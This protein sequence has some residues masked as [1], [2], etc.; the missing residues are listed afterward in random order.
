MTTTVWAVSLVAGE[1]V[2]FRQSA[3]IVFMSG[4]IVVLKRLFAA[5]VLYARL[6]FRPSTLNSEITTG[7]DGFINPDI[8]NSFPVSI[9]KE[10]GLFEIW[11]LIL[12]AIG[13]EH[14]ARITRRSAATVTALTGV[15]LVGSKVGIAFLASA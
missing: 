5:C 1:D 7:L 4:I 10:V 15:V 13:L 9:L 2:T 3:S 14:S 6:W 12:I 11:F 8:A